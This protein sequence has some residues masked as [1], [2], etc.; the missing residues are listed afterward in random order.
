MKEETAKLLGKADQALHAA[1]I[2][3]DAGDAESAIGRAY[4]A[5]FHAPQPLLREKDLRFRKHGSVHAAYGQHFAKAGVLDPKFHRW[6]LAAFNARIKT[7][8]D[9]EPAIDNESAAPTIEQAREF[10]DAARRYLE[11]AA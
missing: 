11:G 10:L 4:Y 6:L 2:L 1:T 3:L 8:Y 7:D 9:I 5:M